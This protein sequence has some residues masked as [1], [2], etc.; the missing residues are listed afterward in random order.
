M[1]AEVKTPFDRI[2]RQKSEIM[3]QLAAMSDEQR[4]AHSSP[5]HWSVLEIVEH[6]IIY[7][8]M[9]VGWMKAEDRAKNTDQPGIK[10]TLFVA[11]MSVMMKLPFRVPTISTMNPSGKATLPELQERW[12]AVRD[13]IHTHLKA[14]MPE[15]LDCALALHPQAGPLDPKQM[16][17]LFEVHLAYHQRQVSALA[18]AKHAAH[19]VTVQRGKH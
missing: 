11:L 17:R 19:T 10:G 18:A 14:V 15:T 6:L 5:K 4:H 2:E 7:E 8:E 3:A 13:S 16:L 9:A 1:L 12:Q